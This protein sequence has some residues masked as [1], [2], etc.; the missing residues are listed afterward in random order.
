MRDASS[1]SYNIMIETGLDFEILPAR[2]LEA[3]KID[4]LRKLWLHGV[5]VDTHC[6]GW[7][8]KSVFEQRLETNDVNTCWRN[9]DLVGWCLR[10]ES[11]ARKVMKIYQIWVRPDA[12]IL[13]HGRAL[14]SQIE[15]AAVTVGDGYLEAWVAEDLAANYFWNAIGF[16]RGVW[17]W[18]RGQSLRKIYRYTKIAGKGAGV[19]APQFCSTGAANHD[20][21]EWRHPF[22][23]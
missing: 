15:E 3:R 13:E 5:Q 18:G 22:H 20:A 16:V 9:G 14:I 19:F 7:L 6:V 2:A 23:G 21:T 8:P 12:R 10:G 4:E 11:V 1:G 17:R